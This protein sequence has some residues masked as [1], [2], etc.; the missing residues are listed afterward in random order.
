LLVVDE[1]SMVDVLLMRSLLK[2]LPDS[3]GLLIVAR[4]TPFGGPLELCIKLESVPL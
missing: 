3:A 4:W 1:A 2:A